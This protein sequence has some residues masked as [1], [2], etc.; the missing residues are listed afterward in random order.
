M[1]KQPAMLFYP[2]DWMKDPALRSVSVSARGLWID[3]LCLMHESPRRGYLQHATGKPVTA[4]QIARMTG[5]STDEVSRL[6]QELEYSGVFSCTEHGVIYS[7]RIVRDESI[8]EKRREAG[9]KGG[10]PRL[11]KQNATKPQPKP[12][13]SGKQKPTPSF[14]SSVSTSVET[15]TPPRSPP[16][17]SRSGKR[18][19]QF[20]PRSVPLPPPLDTAAFRSAWI[21]WCDD[22]QDRRK[23]I[24]KRAAT[25]QIAKLAKVGEQQAIAAIRTAIERGWQGLFP[26][27]STQKGAGKNGSGKRSGYVH[28]PKAPVKPL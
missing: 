3:L 14:S 17:E 20:D 2:G 23:P 7:R 15:N 12:N 28:D 26:D 11:L 6:L 22:R 18:R 24:T 5:C 16:G 10:N 19:S 21:D 9:R 27:S 4:E 8:R 25:L 1:A 13:Q